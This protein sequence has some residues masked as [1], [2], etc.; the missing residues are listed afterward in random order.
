[1]LE[2]PQAVL[3]VFRQLARSRDSF[4]NCLGD[5][6]GIGGHLIPL[7]I[8]IIVAFYDPGRP[9][10]ELLGFLEIGRAPASRR[11]QRSWPSA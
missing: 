10:A 11:G 6:D 2:G 9:E 7:M 4:L 8:R 3:W 5:A 1:M